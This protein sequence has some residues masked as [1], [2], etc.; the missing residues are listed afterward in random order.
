M[1]GESITK[2]STAENFIK[3]NTD[4]R[5]SPDAI[6]PFIAA[7]DDVTRLVIV[8]ASNLADAEKRTTILDRDMTAA[9]KAIVQDP[10]QAPTPDRMFALL[11]T[12]STDDLAKVINLIEDWLKARQT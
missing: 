4:K 2:P 3:A 6:A 10:N 9:F 1:P 11:D 12:L 7:L 8:K 5:L